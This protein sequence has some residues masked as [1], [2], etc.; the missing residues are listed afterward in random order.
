L[1]K[2][3]EALEVKLSSG[4]WVGIHA[5]SHEEHAIKISIS[6]RDFLKSDM[7]KHLLFSNNVEK[8]FRQHKKLSQVE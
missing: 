6:S 8:F 1:R 3:S 4:K 2:Y 5:T 7:K